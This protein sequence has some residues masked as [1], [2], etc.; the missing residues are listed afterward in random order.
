MHS[1]LRPVCGRLVAGS[2]VLVYVCLRCSLPWMGIAHDPFSLI[3]F[4][5]LGN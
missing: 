4:F 2:D 1:F 3:S 5:A